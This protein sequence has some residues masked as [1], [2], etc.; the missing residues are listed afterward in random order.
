MPATPTLLER[1]EYIEQAYFFRALSERMQLQMAMQDLLLSVKE[2]LLSSARL[3]LAI[4]FM[5]GELK[6]HGVFATA[7]ARLKHYFTPFQT[8]VIAQAESERGRFDLNMALEILHREATYKSQDPAPQGEF[9]FQFEALCR[10]RLPYDRGL[11]AMAED[12]IYD[13]PWRDFLRQLRRQIGIVDIADVIYVRSQYYHLMQSRKRANA[14][15]LPALFGEREGKI[16]LANRKRDPLLLF[17]AL[18]RHLNYPAVPRARRITD[19]PQ[20]LPQLIRRIEKL[21]ARQKLLEEEQ[22]GGID[23]TRFFASGGNSQAVPPPDDLVDPA[24][25]PGDSV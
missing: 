9:L 19:S 12:P 23:L 21:E 17:A 13:E 6:L 16:A 11:D 3:P 14:P 1:E 15:E 22:R 5:V 24:Q 4:D 7:M 8:F 2:E 25:F 20:L 18:Q 10:N